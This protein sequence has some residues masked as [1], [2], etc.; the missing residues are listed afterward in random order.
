MNSMN[1]VARV[2]RGS[3]AEGE[4]IA[5]VLSRVRDELDQIA[6]SIDNMQAVVGE[7]TW[8]LARQDPEYMKAMQSVDHSAQV[9]AGLGEFLVALVKDAPTDWKLNP[10]AASKIVRLADL[11]A[12]LATS[13]P[14]GGDAD[15]SGDCDFF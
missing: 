14:A 10:N 6:S 3:E 12:R 13:S 7:L 9:V 2:E 15:D 5:D 1:A 8:D 11:A 4:P